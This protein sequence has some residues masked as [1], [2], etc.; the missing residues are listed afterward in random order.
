MYNSNVINFMLL[1]LI[2]LLILM[3]FKCNSSLFQ[4]PKFYNFIRKRYFGSSISFLQYNI[5]LQVFPKLAE[6][7]R[8][9]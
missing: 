9:Y 5:N 2:M 4:K 3:L 8:L 7:R 6:T 1:I